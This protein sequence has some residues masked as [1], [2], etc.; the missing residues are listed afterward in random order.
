MIVNGFV[1]V[2]ITSIEKRFDLTST[3]SGTIA[4]FYDISAVLCLI[5]VSYFGG[6][7]RKPRWVST[8]MFLVGLGSFI[9]GLPHFTTGLYEYESTHDD[10]QCMLTG[11]VRSN[12]T[13]MTCS[14]EEHVSGL[15]RYKY[16]F[17]VAQILHGVGATPLST[18]AITYMDE[19]LKAKMTPVYTG[20]TT[21][22]YT[23]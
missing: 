9:F 18:L 16:M 11:N 15:N 3:E 7:G 13:E 23:L 12:M 6:F 20:K 5:P 2:V 17:I 21:R 10:N 14:K 4:S 22:S 19:N 1:N 8:G